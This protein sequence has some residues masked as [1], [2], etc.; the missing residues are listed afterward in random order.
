MR[1]RPTLRLLH[2][3]TAALALTT[4]PMLAQDTDEIYL[5]DEI[6][7]SGGLTG[8]AKDNFTR[9]YSILTAEDLKE[10]GITTVQDALRSLPGVSVASTGDSITSVYIRGGENNHVKVLIDGVEANDTINGTYSFSGLSVSNIAKIEVLR[11]PQSALYGTSAMSGVIS[12]TTKHAEQ[13]G[14]S[15]GGGFEIGEGD[16][17]SGNLYLRQGFE[18]GQLSFATETRRSDYNHGSQY[19]GGSVANETDTYTFTGDTEFDNGIKI[20]FSLRKLD[21]SY[22]YYDTNSGV[23]G[24]E[25]YLTKNG[26]SVD[27]EEISGAL[28]LE[29]EALGGRLLNRFE[30]SGMDQD[31]TYYSNWGTSAFKSSRRSFK[32][33]GSYALDGGIARMAAQK[34]NLLLETQH[35]SFDYGGTEDRNTHSIALDYQGQFD[36]GWDLQAGLRRDFIDVFDDPTSWNISTAWDVPDHALRL[37]GSIGRATSYPSMYEQFGYAPDGQYEGNPDLKPESSLSYELGVDLEFADGTGEIG[38]TLFYNEVEDLIQSAGSSSENLD[39]TSTR[40][41]VEL[42][43]NWQV[44]DWLMLDASYTYTNAKDSDGTPLTRRPEH[45]FL[46]N[47]SMSAFQDQGTL[48][49]SL[50]HVA[51]SYDQEWWESY[52]PDTTKLPD[53]TT[54]NLAAQYELTEHVNLTARVINLFDETY[55]EAWGYYGQG[56]TFY[57]GLNTAW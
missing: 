56:R 14:M 35:E 52:S 21:Q 25:Y 37:R 16:Q 55:S 34:L 47:A 1:A 28:W 53:F 19:S 5:L 54:I 43:A 45:E 22:E 40:K 20:G 48:S 3:T 15:Y 38:A 6:V 50:R 27:R 44:A 10:R 39:G 32:Y 7:V 33:T 17:Y 23:S 12:I 29:A 41:G 30:A 51:N 57:V 9:D 42:T 31:T 8:I 18:T 36:N 46:L 49:A 26:S 13:P 24:P 4:S 11:G 2:L